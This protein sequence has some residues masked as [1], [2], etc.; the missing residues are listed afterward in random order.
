MLNRRFAENMEEK[1]SFFIFVTT[2]PTFA[3]D[4]LIP[5]D[6]PQLLCSGYPAD[7]PPGVWFFFNPYYS[8]F[9]KQFLDNI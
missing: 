7:R 9:R 5:C 1:R 2:V 8:S 3:A 6:K 4:K